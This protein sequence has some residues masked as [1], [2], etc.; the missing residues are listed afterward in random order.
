M[1]QKLGIGRLD[2]GW[3]TLELIEVDDCDVVG[4]LAYFG[5]LVLEVEVGELGDIA[6]FEVVDGFGEGQSSQRKEEDHY[7][8]LHTCNI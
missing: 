7:L 5:D 8:T 6:G 4:V 3:G 1:G 2:E